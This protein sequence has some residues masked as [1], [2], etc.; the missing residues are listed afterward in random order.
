MVNWKLYQC[1]R[2]RH[3]ISVMSWLVRS[4]YSINVPQ[5]QRIVAIHLMVCDKDG[6]SVLRLSK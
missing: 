3:Q 2:C 4:L 6:V 1:E 5:V